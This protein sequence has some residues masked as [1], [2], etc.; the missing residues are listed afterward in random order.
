MKQDILDF[1]LKNRGNEYTPPKMPFGLSTIEKARWIMNCGDFAWLELDLPIPDLK[2]ECAAAEK[3]YVQHREGESD[4]W[5]SC[6]IHGI[7]TDTTQTW[8]EYVNEETND[9]YKWTELSNEV[10]LTT[11]FWKNFPAE[12][13]KRVRF[14][15]LK[16]GGYIAPHSDA[17]GSGYEPG[18]PVDYDPL[19]LGCPINVALIHPHDCHMLLDGFGKIPFQ[20]GKAFLINIRHIHAVLN[21]SQQTRIHMIGFVVPGNRKEEFAELIVRSYER[22]QV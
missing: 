15:K 2:A 4:G 6:C 7:R 3:Y 21:F 17:P 14:M 13:F 1:Y 22:S 8:C 18:E 16:P 5:D 11:Q 12:S 9:T 19:E 20:E 10:P